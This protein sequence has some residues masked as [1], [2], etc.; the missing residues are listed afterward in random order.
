MLLKGV[1]KGNPSPDRF[2][3][4]LDDLFQSP[5]FGYFGKDTETRF[6]G[7]SRRQQCGELGRK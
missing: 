6:E 1:G 4:R 2:Q 3:Q 7:K 5:L